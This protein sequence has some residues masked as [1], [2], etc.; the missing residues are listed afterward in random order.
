MKPTCFGVARCETKLD[1][2]VSQ[3][4]TLAQNPSAKLRVIKVFSH[5]LSQGV[6][7]RLLRTWGTQ[8]EPCNINNVQIG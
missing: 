6:C 8:V 1:N 2:A 4:S 7:D 5:F 3:H